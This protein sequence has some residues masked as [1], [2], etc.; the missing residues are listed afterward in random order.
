VDKLRGLVALEMIPALRKLAAAPAGAALICAIVA[1][2]QARAAG[3]Y[4]RP[5]SHARAHPRA[6]ADGKDT[7]NLQGYSPAAKRVLAQARA[8][9]GGDGWSLLRGWHEIGHE[10]GAKYE[11]W[12]DT[13][14]YGMRV[15]TRDASG[16]SVRGFNGQ[17]AWR[18]QPSGAAA[19]VEERAL[20]ARARTEAFLG[21]Y[22]FFYSGRFDA[23][24][25]SLGVRQ[26]R[27]RSF[28]VITVHPWDGTPR[29][30]WFDCSSHL[31]AR[32]VDRSGPQAVTTELSDYRKVGP[33]KAAFHATIEGA[34]PPGSQDIKVDSIVFT[35]AERELFS[36]PRPGAL[37]QP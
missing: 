19:G 13:L 9:S 33:I 10:G 32:I 34:I 37:A 29:E 30:L 31:L 14:R 6:P 36:L 11:S 7:G 22:G 17:G 2:P 3:F 18:I 16:L 12:F 8:A 28:D 25:E 21:A 26:L 4:A 27:G 23:H 24:G 1:A 20:V 15:E 5:A 35:T